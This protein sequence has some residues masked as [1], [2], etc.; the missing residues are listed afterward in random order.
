MKNF[1]D[2][3]DGISL[4]LTAETVYARNKALEQI[5]AAAD[6]INYLLYVREGYKKPVRVLYS[7]YSIVTVT[8]NDQILYSEING[9]NAELFNLEGADYCLYMTEEEA[10][11]YSHDAKE[12]KRIVKEGITSSVLLDYT[13][14]PAEYLSLIEIDAEINNI[15]E[16]GNYINSIW[17]YPLSEIEHVINSGISVV[18]VQG[19][20]GIR[21]VEVPCEYVRCFYRNQHL[22]NKKESI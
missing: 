11:T 8:F 4:L 19:N 6:D 5:T 3:V 2:L 7:D 12:I 9:Y 10:K 21:W 13:L 16:I 22:N 18:L 14:S 1:E 20:D 15:F 17:D